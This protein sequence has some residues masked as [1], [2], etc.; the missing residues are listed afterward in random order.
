MVLITFKDG[1]SVRLHEDDSLEF[2][3]GSN[4]DVD[5]NYHMI[6]ATSEAK[7]VDS[8]KHIDILYKDID[9]RLGGVLSP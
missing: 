4:T 1:V 6:M 8:E 7:F 9:K 5:F 2:I 3:T